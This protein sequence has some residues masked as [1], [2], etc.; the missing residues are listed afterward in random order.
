MMSGMMGGGGAAS[1]KGSSGREM[2]KGMAKASSGASM[3][4][5]SPGAPAEYIPGMMMGGSRQISR[6]TSPTYDEHQTQAAIARTEARPLDRGF[7]NEE[8]DW[9]QEAEA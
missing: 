2:M 4:G 6:A 1:K 7:G 5:P 9:G 8:S 3:T